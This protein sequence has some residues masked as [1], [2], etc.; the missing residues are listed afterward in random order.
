MKGLS[1]RNA[2]SV[3][4]LPTPSTSLAGV[5]VLLTTDNKPYWCNGTT[6]VDLTASGPASPAGND[7]EIQ[8]N[9]AGSTAGAANVEIDNGDLVL[10]LNNSPVTPP[11]NTVK[12]FGRN[13]ANR[14]FPAMVGPSGMDVTLQPAVW[15]QK[16]ARWNPPGNATTVPGVDGFAAQT[17]VGTATARTVATTNLMT[18]TKRLGYVSAAT[19][20]SLTGH[21]STAAQ[22]TTGNGTGLGGFFYS[23]RFAFS[24]AAAVSGVRSFVGLTSSVAAFTNVE[25]N[26]LTN[27]IGIAQLSTDATQLFLVYG[28]SAAQTAVALGTNFAPYNGTVGVTTGNFFDLTIFCA[29]S[30]NG[31][32]NV[33]LENISNGQVY[34]NTIT[35]G[36]PGTQTPANTTLLAHRAWRT[37][38][39]TAL[40]VGIDIAGIYIET[41]Y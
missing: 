30:S 35:P 41:D 21:Y 24:D 1:Y 15:R 29:P 16:V 32:V 20:G 23:C 3:G 38:N 40:A 10:I 28:G 14:M 18:R 33:R 17:A 19:A 8:Y 6:W 4:S 37:N 31:V 27:A 39:A 5:T 13:L 7:R 12:L 2:V 9:N 34:S 11:A 22:F 36:T 25:P 26:T